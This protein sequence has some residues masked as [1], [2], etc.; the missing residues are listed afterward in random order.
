MKTLFKLN[1][2]LNLDVKNVENAGFINYF[3]MQRFGT[4]NVRTH[5]I[6]IENLKQ[7]WEKVC[8]MIISQ[9][10]DYDDDVKYTKQKMLKLVFEDNNVHAAF[11]LL[12]RRDV[13]I[14]QSH[15]NFVIII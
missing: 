12:E 8:R 3:G 11:D 2:F 14:S 10:P 4:Y 1:D 5:E 15:L 7:D 13:I 9:H 6:G